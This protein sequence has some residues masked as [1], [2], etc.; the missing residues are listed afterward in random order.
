MKLFFDNT[1]IRFSK[2]GF[3]QTMETAEE[4]TSTVEDILE[5]VYD[6]KTSVSSN[7]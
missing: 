1:K 6:D 7:L 2:K 3:K 4:I 5:T